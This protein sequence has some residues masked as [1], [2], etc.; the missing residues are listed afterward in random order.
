MEEGISID[1]ACANNVIGTKEDFERSCN[2]DGTV[3]KQTNTTTF[4]LKNSDSSITVNNT[5]LQIGVAVVVIAVIFLTVLIIGKLKH[6][7]K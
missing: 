3:K 7:A 6:K 4:S 1:E 5:Y 2:P